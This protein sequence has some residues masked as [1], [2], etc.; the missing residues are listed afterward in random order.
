MRAA[1]WARCSCSSPALAVA[2]TNAAWSWPSVTQTLEHAVPGACRSWT[3]W[4]PA[5]GMCG[6]RRAKACPRKWWPAL[7]W[8]LC[9]SWSACI[10]R[11]EQQLHK[12][13]LAPVICWPLFRQSRQIDPPLAAHQAA[14]ACWLSSCTAGC[15]VNTYLCIR[16]DRHVLIQHRQAP[17]CKVADLAAQVSA[18]VQHTRDRSCCASMHCCAQM[19]VWQW[20]LF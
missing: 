10:R 9:P 16:S 5:C 17:V 15:P 3:C 2:S 8:R 19:L 1:C 20:W 7:L 11:G 14:G 13:L 12:K 4:A 18:R 6:T